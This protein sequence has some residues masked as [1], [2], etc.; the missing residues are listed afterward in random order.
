MFV[1]IDFVV[2]VDIVAVVCCFIVASTEMTTI[3]F[4]IRHTLVVPCNL[5]NQKEMPR[6]YLIVIKVINYVCLFDRL[7]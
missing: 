3:A 2:A 1:V 5:R 6:T 4:V 7:L